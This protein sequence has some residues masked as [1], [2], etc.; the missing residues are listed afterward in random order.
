[1]PWSS[2]RDQAADWLRVC[3]RK[4]VT[5]LGDRPG[6][7][8]QLPQEGPT[9]DNMYDGSC[10]MATDDLGVIVLAPS[11]V[12]GG[13]TINWSASFH[14][15]DH[16]LDEWRNVHGLHDLFGISNNAYER[17]LEAVCERM[18]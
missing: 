2:D 15:S 1:M 16:V 7:G 4:P 18:G 9:L 14:S 12:G 5:K 11:T 17:A 8:R 13:S 10:F 6:E 3:S